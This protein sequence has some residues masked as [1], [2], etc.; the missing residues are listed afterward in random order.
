MIRQDNNC[1]CSL[2]AEKILYVQCFH[3]KLF[4]IFYHIVLSLLVL[5]DTNCS[6]F[7]Y[8]HDDAFIP[9]FPN[10]KILTPPGHGSCGTIYRK[11]I[12]LDLQDNF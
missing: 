4:K 12:F 9:L 1:N 5:Y 2:K 8:L 3:T 6:L 10:A 7:S 11:I